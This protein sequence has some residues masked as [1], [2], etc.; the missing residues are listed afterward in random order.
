MFIL[1]YFLLLFVK[2]IHMNVKNEQNQNISD[3]IKI[4]RE[5]LNLSKSAVSTKMNLSRGMC[6]QW[7][8]GISNP[9]TAHLVKL[10]DVLGVSFE[11]LATG[12]EVMQASEIMLDENMQNIKIGEALTKLSREQKHHLLNFLDLLD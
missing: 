6:A 5:N 2:N 12:K 3:R 8:S 10:A 7:E 1:N 4:S 11:W 9:S